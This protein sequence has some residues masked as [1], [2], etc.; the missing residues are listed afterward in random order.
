MDRPKRAA[1][2]K[3]GNFRTFYL[4][5]GLDQEIRGLVDARVEQFSMAST[6]ELKQ[7][8]EAER[9]SNRKLE[10]DLEHA[11]VQHELEME[12]MKREQ[13]QAAMEKLNEAKEQAAQEHAKCMSQ[14]G[15]MTT[16]AGEPQENTSVEWLRS[17]MDRITNTAPESSSEARRLQQEKEE[18]IQAIRT[19]QDELNNRLKELQGAPEEEDALETIRKALAPGPTQGKQ[20][21]LLQQLKTALQGKKEE[22]PNKILLKALITQQNKVTGEGGT[23]SLKPHLINKMADS[24]SMADWLANLN[25]QEEGEFDLAKYSLPGEEEQ[26]KQGRVRSG[27]LD[28]ATANKAVASAESGRGLGR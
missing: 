2:A 20:E 9:E 16:K 18:A 19:Q 11:K 7:Q 26:G 24:K 23:N 15:S 12:K 22:D 8:L 14:I 28:K 13:W 27:I 4:S 21:V 6:E 10:E 3:V 17:Q 5:G 25:R 1:A